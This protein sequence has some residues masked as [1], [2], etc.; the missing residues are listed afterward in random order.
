MWLGASLGSLGA[1][2]LRALAPLLKCLALAKE[3]TCVA[4]AVI[5]M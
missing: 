3:M 1:N 2:S 4:A 5:D